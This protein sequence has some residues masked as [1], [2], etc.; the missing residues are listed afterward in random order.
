MRKKSKGSLKTTKNIPKNKYYLVI[1]IAVV[2]VILLF[3][4]LVK[5]LLD[6]FKPNYYSIV[7]RYSNVE[8]KKTDA[9]SKNS[10]YDVV[11][12]VRVQGTKIDFPVV[13]GKDD[14]FTNPVESTA[15]GW[16]GSYGDTDYHNVMT[17]YG[18]NIMNLGR[19]PL[20][21][22]ESFERFEEL[23]AFTDYDFAE[24]NLYFQYTMDG[25]EYLYKIFAVSILSPSSMYALPEGDFS[26][27]EVSN[28]IEMLKDDSIYNYDVRVNSKDDIISLVTCTALFAPEYKYND[29][30]ISGKRVVD[31]ESTKSYS[32][33][34]TT[35]YDNLKNEMKG[36]VDDEEVE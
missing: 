1:G 4:L 36:D 33:S 16:L 28:Y 13:S 11:G 29:I 21:S 34:K 25:K 7:S 5:S 14:S 26:E 24:K 32:V 12:W 20:V 22:D 3:I 27:S 8:K 35:K 30:V 6:Y 17:I 9:Q 19:K 18:H 31:G 23:L 15:Y 2:I 10:N